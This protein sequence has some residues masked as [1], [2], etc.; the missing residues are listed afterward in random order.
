MFI[1]AS[2]KMNAGL[3]ESWGLENLAQETA[4]FHD[5]ARI[6]GQQATINNRLATPRFTTD[7]VGAKNDYTHNSPVAT[8]K[9][10][11]LF[12]HSL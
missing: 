10:W 11:T 9:S 2:V 1:A 7:H 4:Y 12:G 8:F 6:L 5:S 3:L